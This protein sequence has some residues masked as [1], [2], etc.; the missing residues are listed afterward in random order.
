MLSGALCKYRR[1]VFSKL[2]AQNERPI[3]EGRLMLDHAHMMIGI[4]LDV[5]PL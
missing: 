2:A 3:G 1:E 5:T 4:A